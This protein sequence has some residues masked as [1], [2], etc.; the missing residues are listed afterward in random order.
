MVFM[1]MSKIILNILN[2]FKKNIKKLEKDLKIVN[3]NSSNVFQ[4]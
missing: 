4:D 3:N 2:I 1:L